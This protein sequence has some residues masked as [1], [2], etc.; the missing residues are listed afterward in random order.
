MPTSWVD[1]GYVAFLRG[2]DT[3]TWMASLRSLGGAHPTDNDLLEVMIIACYVRWLGTQSG[4]KAAV[5]EAQAIY[6]T[7]SERLVKLHRERPS[8]PTATG[9]GIVLSMMG[10]TAAGKTYVAAD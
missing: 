8:P 4:E 10:Y 3:T 6:R 5:D 1:R 7:V 9:M 2:A